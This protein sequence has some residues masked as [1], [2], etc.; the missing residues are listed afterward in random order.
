MNKRSATIHEVADLAGVSTATVARVLKKKGYVSDLSR[1]KVLDAVRATNYRPNV[2]ARGLKTQRSQTIGLM[3]TSITV[4]PIF[5]GVAHAIELAAADAGYHTI[6]FNHRG[7][8]DAER[9]GVESFLAQRVDAVIFCT[10]INAQ[11]VETLIAAGVPAIEVERA[12]SSETSFVRVDNVVGA[13]AAVDHLAGLGHER[14]AFIGGDP[15]IHAKDKRRAR[16]VED[17]RLSAFRE[18]LLGNGLEFDPDLISLGR[19]YD[20]DGSTRI[21]Q[22]T[23]RSLMAKSNRPTA[24]F[25]TCDILAAGVLQELYASNIRV[26]DDI[27]IIGFDDTIAAHLSPQLTTVSQPVRQMGEVAFQAAL[28]GINGNINGHETVLP[29][30]LNI[31]NST[32]LVTRTS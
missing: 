17:D 10:A 12:M 25:A 32:R 16:S 14:I 31:R 3:L 6:I 26:P 28:K 24:I 7:D 4:N 18:G 23:T 21:G 15:A 11:A 5:V 22:Q 30:T 20:D 19:Y 27:S 8:P 9:Q 29:S 1:Q 13:R 2:M